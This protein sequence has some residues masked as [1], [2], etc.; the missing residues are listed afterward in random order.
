VDGRWAQ[1]PV[2]VVGG[3]PLCH[4]TA[5]E[6]GHALELGPGLPSPQVGAGSE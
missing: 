5:V 2:A 1:A 6:P 4:R 3:S